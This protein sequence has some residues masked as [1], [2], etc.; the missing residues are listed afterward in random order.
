MGGYGRG[1]YGG[2]GMMNQYNTAYN[3]G[4]YNMGRSAQ[5]RRMM[6]YGGY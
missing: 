3:G 4:M 1:M 5:D 2:M 6:R